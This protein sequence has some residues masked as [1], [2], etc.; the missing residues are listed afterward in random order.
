MPQIYFMYISAFTQTSKCLLSH[1]IISVNLIS[2]DISLLYLDTE[3]FVV[4]AGLC[5]FTTFIFCYK[6]VAWGNKADVVFDRFQLTSTWQYLTLASWHAIYSPVNQR[7]HSE[8]E[9]SDKIN[10]NR[11]ISFAFIVLKS[12]LVIPTSI[13]S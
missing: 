8:R 12:I 1:E 7:V 4:Y 3:I 6:T 5:L 13:P 9:I 2:F 11:T 10:Y